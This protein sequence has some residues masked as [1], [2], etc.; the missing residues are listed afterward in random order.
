MFSSS[1]KQS[2]LLIYPSLKFPTKTNQFSV[3]NIN[4]HE[5]IFFAM[6]NKFVHRKHKLLDEASDFSIA[7]TN[8]A[9]KVDVFIEK[10][11]A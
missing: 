1:A 5:N 4:F 9:F 7:K 3:E 11:I 10:T 2:N 8:V 6:T